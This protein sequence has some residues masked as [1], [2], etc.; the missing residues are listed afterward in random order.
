MSVESVDQSTVDLSDPLCG[1]EEFTELVREMVTNA[2]PQLFAVV[3][4]VGERFDGR[5]AAWGLAFA[6]GAEVYT[7]GGNVRMSLSSAEQAI[8][9]FGRGKDISVRLVWF[10]SRIEQG[11][12]TG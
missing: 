8:R 5:I 9:L 11:A 3:Q 1:E 4:E 10:E 12:A 7:I 6:E 2:A